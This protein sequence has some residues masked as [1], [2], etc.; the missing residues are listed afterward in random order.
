MFLLIT[1]VDQI[2]RGLQKLHLP[3]ID[4]HKLQQHI[5]H[6]IEKN[7]PKS[8]EWLKSL[9][10]WTPKEKI[11]DTSQIYV[12]WRTGEETMPPIVK[13]CYKNLRQNAKKHPITL[14]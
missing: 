14:I 2:N 9:A 10:E 1:L 6:Q 4:P 5:F 3:C 7:V 8:I 12:M 13:L 11:E